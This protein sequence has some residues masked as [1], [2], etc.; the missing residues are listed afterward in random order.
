MV[1][2][3]C[4]LVVFTVA[5]SFV[6]VGGL[7]IAAPVR[8]EEVGLWRQI[9]YNFNQLRITLQAICAPPAV[10]P[11]WGYHLSQIHQTEKQKKQ[12]K[13]KLIAARK[14]WCKNADSKQA[15]QVSVALHWGGGKLAINSSTPVVM[16]WSR[17]KSTEVWLR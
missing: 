7:V 12:N 9:I 15:K 13:T 16:A 2:F 8:G 3:H 1:F 6:F 10:P 17:F 14:F 11:P 4:H 5:Q